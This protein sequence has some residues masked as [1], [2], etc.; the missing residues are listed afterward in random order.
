MLQADG[1][2]LIGHTTVESTIR[3]LLATSDHRYEVSPKTWVRV[4]HQNMGPSLT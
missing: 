3:H 1:G 4:Y 2:L